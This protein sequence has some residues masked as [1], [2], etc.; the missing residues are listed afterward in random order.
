M[1]LARRNCAQS[2]G[3][4]EH[5]ER[6]RPEW[7]GQ[8]RP[9][10]IEPATCQLVRWMDSRGM[11][12]VRQRS[13]PSQGLPSGGRPT[14]ITADEPKILLIGCT[15]AVKTNTASTLK[16]VPKTRSWGRRCEA[17]PGLAEIPGRNRVKALA[18]EEENKE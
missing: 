18:K 2:G 15:E 1:L 9:E 6:E 17:T 5:E 12:W 14:G 16:E 4:P 13:P 10:R 7:Q 11:L 8:R 3:V